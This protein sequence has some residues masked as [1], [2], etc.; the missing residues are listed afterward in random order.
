MPWKFEFSKK[1]QK[2]F[3]ALDEKLQSRIKKA[4][5][6]KVMI[7]PKKYLIRLSGDKS[8][9]YKFRVGDCRLLCAK[10]DKKFSVLVIKVKHR[11]EVY[12]K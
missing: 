9:F 4:F 5:I 6:E 11:R 2:Q 3:Y 7:N 12:R 10:D 8:M 1:A